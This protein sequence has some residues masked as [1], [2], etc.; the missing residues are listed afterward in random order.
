MPSEKKGFAYFVPFFFFFLLSIEAGAHSNILYGISLDFD[1]EQKMGVIQAAQ[2]FLNVGELP[3]M[4]DYDFE[5]IAAKF[6]RKLELSVLVNPSDNSI[7][8]F[9]DDSLASSGKE[10]FSSEKMREIAER[11]FEKYVPDPY[12]KELS[13][14][15]EKKLYQGVYEFTWFRYADGVAVMNEHFTVEVDPV[16]GDIVSFRLSLFSSPK[17]AIRTTPAIP[18]EVAK[19][20]G[21]LSLNGQP[22][23]ADP[24][25]LINKDRPLWLVK[26]KKIYPI[27]AGI[28]AL[29]GRVVFSGNARTE[30]PPGYTVGKDVP[31]VETEL[32]RSILT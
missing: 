29:D 25:L 2:K 16:D 20:I 14:A 4:F 9:R 26:V 24:L 30:L 12:K 32:L 13:F 23:P 11:A 27:F 1:K 31:V 21:E 10:F 7:F 22:L 3:T 6:D 19:K 18:A 8:G 5:L 17:E 15:G 28:D